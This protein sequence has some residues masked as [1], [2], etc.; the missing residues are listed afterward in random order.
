MAGL[1]PAIHVVMPDALGDHLVG[2]LREPRLTR[3]IE[4]ASQPARGWPG[5]ARTSPAMTMRKKVEGEK[6]R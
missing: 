1:V 2:I 4:T 6:S 5:Q 3:N